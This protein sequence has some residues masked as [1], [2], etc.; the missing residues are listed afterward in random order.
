MKILLRLLITVTL[1]IWVTL[2]ACAQALLKSPKYVQTVIGDVSDSR[3]TAKYNSQCIIGLKFIGDATADAAD[4]IRLRPTKAMDNLNRNLAPLRETDNPLAYLDSGTRKES[5]PLTGTLFLPSPSRNATAIKLLEGEVE[6]FCP[7]VANGGLI[8]LK[9]LSGNFPNPIEN[10]AL[11]KHGI[12]IFYLTKETFQ[13]RKVE[14][15]RYKYMANMQWPNA[16]IPARLFIHNPSNHVMRVDF[17]YPGGASMAGQ[18]VNYFREVRTVELQTLPP[19]GGQLLLTVM[20][21]ETKRTF[22]F[23]LENI[24]L[25]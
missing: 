10:P 23:K 18:T 25:P 20:T 17:Q 14:L 22:A 4:V 6:F 7:T 2:S 16:K 24:L 3:T 1:G 5:G 13:A 12:E 11:K 9:D 8:L 21:S 19:A 15:A